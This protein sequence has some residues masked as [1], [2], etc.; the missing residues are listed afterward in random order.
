MFVSDGGAK[1]PRHQDWAQQ[2]PA[3]SRHADWLG[4]EAPA[5]ASCYVDCTGQ[6]INRIGWKGR[7]IICGRAPKVA[8]GLGPFASAGASEREAREKARR[9]RRREGAWVF[10]DT[11]KLGATPAPA[12]IDRSN[13]HAPATP[14]PFHKELRAAPDRARL[15]GS[16]NSSQAW[17][18]PR[19]AAAAGAADQWKGTRHAQLPRHAPRVGAPS[20]TLRP[21]PHIAV[22]IDI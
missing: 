1:A 19:Q 4:A 18:L 12:S 11:V 7:R 16:F 17:R 21:R 13:A 6:E 3:E 8:W 9:G 20:C 14:S 5:C 10:K 15:K 2:H 22:A